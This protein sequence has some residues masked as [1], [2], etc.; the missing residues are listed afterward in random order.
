LTLYNDLLLNVG[1]VSGATFCNTSELTRA[2]MHHVSK[3]LG[4]LIVERC[5]NK[6]PILRNSGNFP[7]NSGRIKKLGGSVQLH[8][9]LSFSFTV[10]LVTIYL[11]IP[12][13]LFIPRR[14]IQR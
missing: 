14:K 13:D 1:T 5:N 2:R 9:F 6:D 8:C 11:H 3:N 7:E 10:G 12:S 4:L